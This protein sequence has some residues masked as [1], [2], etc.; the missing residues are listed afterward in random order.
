V[1]DDFKVDL[2][3]VGL[4]VRNTLEKALLNAFRSPSDIQVLARQAEIDVADL[5]GGNNRILMT[6]L[7]EVA[8]SHGRGRQLIRAARRLRPDNAA[9]DAALKPVL[10]RHFSGEQL[11]E[12]DSLLGEAHVP[13]QA[14]HDQALSSIPENAV[15][16]LSKLDGIEGEAERRTS[17]LELLSEYGERKSEDRAHPLLEFAAR[18]LLHRKAHGVEDKLKSWVNRIARLRGIEVSHFWTKLQQEL[19]A[20]FLLVKISEVSAGRF[21]L[22]VYLGH[23]GGPPPIQVAVDDGHHTMQDVEGLLRSYWDD[24]SSRIPKLGENLTIE[25][26]LPLGHLLEPVDQWLSSFGDPLGARYTVVV[27]PLE[28]IYVQSR[29]DPKALLKALAPWKSKWR[30]LSA[31]SSSPVW[32]RDPREPETDSHRAKLIRREIGCVAVTPTAPELSGPSL[33]SFL[34]SWVEKG[35]PAAVWIRRAACQRQDVETFLDEMLRP[36]SALPAKVREQRLAGLELGSPEHFG[37]HLSLLW[38][39][40]GRVPEDAIPTDDFIPAF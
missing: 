37:R 8:A 3:E 31:G 9:L 29:N 15:T 40:P 16:P 38:D 13:W 20:P 6:S 28:R 7:L 34:Q 14:L 36:L 39:D 19:G 4:A 12:L 33:R 24:S 1:S 23:Q 11:Q 27:R 32:V 5:Q 21:Q 30:E 18:L 35:M 17:L 2:L 26:M 22:Q 10:P 25:F